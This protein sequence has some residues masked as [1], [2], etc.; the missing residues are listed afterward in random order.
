MTAPTLSPVHIWRLLAGFAV[1]A[2]SFVFL[3]AL[4]ALG[5]HL[6][7]SLVLLG[8][9]PLN[10][11]LLVAAFAAALCVHL[12]VLRQAAR[13]PE[14]SGPAAFLAVAGLWASSA[15]LLASLLT[16]VPVLF[17]SACL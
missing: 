3:Y 4:Q 11:L 5:C 13:G 1:W 14:G 16:F 15:A 7:W 9:I 17:A 12:L 8:P 2:V 10:R 6:G